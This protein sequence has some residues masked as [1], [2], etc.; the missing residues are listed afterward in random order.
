[1]A[2][3]RPHNHRSR[4][5]LEKIGLVHEGPVA[6]SGLPAVCY[7]QSRAGYLARVAAARPRA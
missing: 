3:A 4:A 5:V 1:M 7:A 6:V 2:V